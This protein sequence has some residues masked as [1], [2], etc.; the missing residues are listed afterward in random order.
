MGKRIL[1]A[2]LALILCAACFALVPLEANAAT[3]ASGIT[4]DVNWKLSSNGVLTIS[5]KGS[6]VDYRMMDGGGPW[7][8]YLENI[9]S[10]I[11]EDGVTGIGDLAFYKCTNIVSVSIPD[12]VELIGTGAFRECTSLKSVKVPNCSIHMGSDIFANCTSL[13]HV[14]LLDGIEYIQWNMFYGCSSLTDIDLPDS[15][16]VISS[17]AFFG[18][19]SLKE[20][21]VPNSVTQIRDAA[22][23]DCANLRTVIIPNSVEM[24]LGGDAFYNCTNLDHILYK[25]T[26]SEWNETEGINGINNQISAANGTIHYECTGSEIINGHCLICDGEIKGYSGVGDSN[27]LWALLIII[28]VFCIGGGAALALFVTRKKKSDS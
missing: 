1:S 25:G 21:T 9:K 28:P 20:I 15:V 5:G 26:E 24:F 14:E 2:V 16:L 4:G 6:M 22:F 23:A 13:K 7:C 12:S 11:I 18:C 8:E 19:S 3:V 17:G 27:V 10:V